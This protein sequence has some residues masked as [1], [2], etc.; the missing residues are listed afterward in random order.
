M[1]DRDYEASSIWWIGPGC[2]HWVV[3]AG[4]GEVE[5][6]S[7]TREQAIEDARAAAEHLRDWRDTCERASFAVASSRNRQTETP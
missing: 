3:Q 7:A 1:N 6:N 4:D 2:W 5:G